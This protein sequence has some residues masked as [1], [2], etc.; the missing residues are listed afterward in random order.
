MRLSASLMAAA[1]ICCAYPSSILA[2]PAPDMVTLST[3]SELATWSISPEKQTHVTPVVFLHG[4]PGLYTEARRF[5]EGAIFRAAGY[6]TLYF[7]Q[8]GGGQSKRL[9]ASEYSLSRAVADLE[10]LRI[11]LGQEK[12]ILWG[13][14]YGASFAAIYA[15]RF[16][17][18]VAGMILTSPGTFPGTNP[19]RTYN[20]TNRGSMKIGKDLTA[21]LSK[22]DRKGAAAEPE[23]S[24]V[25]SGKLLDELMATELIEAMVCK[26]ANITPPPLGR[27]GNLFAN[28]ILLK[29]VEHLKFEATALNVPT[30]I[31]RGACDFM[32]ADNAERY[33]KLFGGQVITIAGNGHGL[34]E[35][36]LSVENS[37]RVFLSGPLASAP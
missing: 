8:A 15:S 35:N 28:R 12:L 14:S 20:L 13:N 17:E 4:G 1:I 16:P 7:D 19:K 3:G 33:R 11:K 30:L 21:A 24:Q 9:K 6:R 18:R 37:I 22:V 32:P 2:Q 26:G 23:V 5:D 29:Q 25:E 31:L 34:L 10:A 27:G 36:R